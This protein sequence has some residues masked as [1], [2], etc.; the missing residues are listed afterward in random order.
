MRKCKLLSIL[1]CAI[2]FLACHEEEQ[3]EVPVTVRTVFMY[4]IGD[5]D[6]S[7]DIYKNIASVE[8]GLKSATSPGTFVI[9][10]DGPTNNEFKV[11]TL[12]KYVVD[13][14]GTV[15][16]RMVIKT[17]SEQ[18]SVDPSIMLGIFNDVKLL[19]PADSYGLILGSHA[20]GWLPT[21]YK[22]SRSL[23]DDNGSRI[24]IPE[25]AD[26]LSRTSIYFDYIL[27]DAC[28]MSQVE[29]AYEFR[30]TADYMIL[31]PAEVLS[32]GFP[33][34]RLVKYLL[35]TDNKK[36]NVINAAK[37]FVDFYKTE[38][39]YHWGTIGVIDLHEMESLAAVTHSIISSYKDKL[40]NFDVSGLQNYGRSD[41]KGSTFDFRDFILQLVDGSVPVDFDEQLNKTVIYKD[42]A[43][44]LLGTL[45]IK[46]SSYSGIG[47]YVP[48]SGY[49]NWNNYFKEIQ[50]YSAAGWNET[51]W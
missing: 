5:N 16:E 23:G 48:Q 3:P 44:D 10:W 42:F 25:L 51:G 9:Y 43:G 35:A 19:C 21:N 49:T 34:T 8:E 24:D 22:R 41:L 38:S 46:A 4:L 31:S 14:Q 39:S 36:E 40:R 29:V 17:Y 32:Y 45:R 28:L 33:Y 11:P 15:S 47:C 26:V 13:D 30:N 1:L 12:F 20:T 7:D 18:N 6:I 37:E 2:V 50:W 27:M